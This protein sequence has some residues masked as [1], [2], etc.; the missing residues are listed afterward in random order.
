MP[1]WQCV[2]CGYFIREANRPPDLCPSCSLRCSFTDVTCYRPECG[3]PL[4]PDPVVMKSVTSKGVTPPLRP[5][6][7]AKE[8]IREEEILYGEKARIATLFHGMSEEEIQK[9][10][11]I[12]EAMI[13]EPGTV[14]FSEN[15]D[16]TT[17]YF[18]ESGRVAI[19]VK[20]G[21][22]EKTIYTATKGDV[23]G[24]STVVLPYQ[25]TAAAVVVEKAKIIAINTTKFQNFCDQNAATCYRVA[26]NFSRA[27]IARLR[28]AKSQEIGKIYG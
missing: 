25:R 2:E 12:G 18:V 13:C 17:M 21:G 14:L 22:K 6:P 3:G 15:D 8:E 19:Q 4:N 10:L 26:Q 16:A 1:K 11:S 23:L 28:F 7:A 9:V 20:E 24:W 27:A 5:S